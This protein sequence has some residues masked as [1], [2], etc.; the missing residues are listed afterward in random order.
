MS[1]R[2]FNTEFFSLCW[3]CSGS[4]LSLLSICDHSAP[5]PL[6]SGGR[7]SE[8]STEKPRKSLTVNRC[9]TVTVIKNNEIYTKKEQTDKR[10]KRTAQKDT[11]TERREKATTDRT[12]RRLIWSCICLVSSLIRWR[13]LIG[14][15]RPSFFSL[16]V[17]LTATILVGFF[18]E[19]D[20]I[21]GDLNAN[22][23]QH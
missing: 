4:L 16:C 8:M 3:L 14:A 17:F 22:V 23:R 19:F 20:D 1:F 6:A 10:T 7:L 5:L 18:V 12:L 2:Q 21:F 11:D 13:I 9:K 15:L